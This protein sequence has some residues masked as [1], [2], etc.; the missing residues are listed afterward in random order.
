MDKFTVCQKDRT[1]TCWHKNAEVYKERSS[2][3]FVG[4]HSGH[5]RIFSN[6]NKLSITYKLFK[7]RLPFNADENEIYS[8]TIHGQG[9][10]GSDDTYY[11]YYENDLIAM[12]HKYLEDVK[13]IKEGPIA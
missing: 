2:G 13:S 10:K 12:E 1:I 4:V 9:T 5:G 7:E 11:E 8:L 3:E 6:K